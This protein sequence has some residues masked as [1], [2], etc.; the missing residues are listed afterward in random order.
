[1]E[2][3]KANANTT[4]TRMELDECDVKLRDRSFGGDDNIL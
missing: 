2:I 3:A 4:G 1:M